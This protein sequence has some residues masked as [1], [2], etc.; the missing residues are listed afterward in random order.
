MGVLDTLL[1]VEKA[2]LGVLGETAE[3]ATD[4]VAAIVKAAAEGV[5]EVIETLGGAIKDE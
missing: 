1:E 3:A 2:L 4:A 5:H